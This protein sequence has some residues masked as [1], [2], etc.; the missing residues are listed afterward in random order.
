MGFTDLQDFQSA[1]KRW[2]MSPILATRLCIGLD[3]FQGRMLK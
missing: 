3:L 2:K 1:H